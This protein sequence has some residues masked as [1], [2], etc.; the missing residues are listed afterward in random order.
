M[1]KGSDTFSTKRNKVALREILKLYKLTY[2]LIRAT[3]ESKNFSKMV[4]TAL[5]VFR[6]SNTKIE[7]RGYGEG[8]GVKKVNGI[9]K[10]FS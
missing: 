9:L 1:N 5:F 2:I 7:N 10:N 4:S 6:N 3:M 8:A